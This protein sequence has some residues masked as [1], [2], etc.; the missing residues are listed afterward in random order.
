MECK[1]CKQDK[2]IEN[3]HW[4]LCLE[5]NR[6]RLDELKLATAYKYPKEDRKSLRVDVKRIK[7]TVKGDKGHKI[8]HRGDKG[9]KSLGNRMLD[10]AFYKKCFELSN[11]KCE[12][13]GEQ[14]PT[15]FL[16]QDGRVASRFRYSHI[17]AKSIAPELR[18]STININHL[19]LECHTKWDFGNKKAMKIYEANSK[20]LPAYF[21]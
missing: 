10:E 6:K 2:E 4:R 17:V 12:E 14:L 13:C 18:H 16:D 1:E 3:K 19:C 8:M 15:E 5:C 9:S 21:T 7:R 11:H 20:K